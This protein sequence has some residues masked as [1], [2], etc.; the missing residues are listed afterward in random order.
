MQSFGGCIPY[1][2]CLQLRA[3]REQLPHDYVYLHHVP[4]YGR[5]MLSQFT[6]DIRELHG[7]EAWLSCAK[8]GRVTSR[9]KLSSATHHYTVDILAYGEYEYNY[10]KLRVII[11]PIAVYVSLF[12]PLEASML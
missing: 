5:A 8:Q 6:F 7:R 12:L 9:V 4:V 3:P 2:G 1:S 10:F 11:H